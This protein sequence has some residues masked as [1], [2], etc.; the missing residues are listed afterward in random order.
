M[1][2]RRLDQSK[3]FSKGKHA[4][5]DRGGIWPVVVVGLI[6]LVTAA[7]YWPAKDAHFVW[8]DE[9][10]ITKSPHFQAGRE[11]GIGWT[12]TSTYSANWHP[13]T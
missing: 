3:R 10:Y 6:L 4:H 1:K 12:L 11:S 5:D 13:L 9:V 8:D 2:R 7:V